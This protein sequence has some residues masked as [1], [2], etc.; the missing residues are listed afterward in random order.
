MN[1][2]KLNI[3]SSDNIKGACGDICM[4]MENFVIAY[5]CPNYKHIRDLEM[6]SNFSLATCL[7]FKKQGVGHV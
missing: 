5:E 3:V 7:E 1:A 4:V 2:D 6:F